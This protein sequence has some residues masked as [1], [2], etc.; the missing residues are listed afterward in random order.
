MISSVLGAPP[1][2]GEKIEPWRLYR[3][4]GK[5]QVTF[6]EC[7]VRKIHRRGRV[8]EKW[9]RKWVVERAMREEG[10]VIANVRRGAAGGERRKHCDH[11]VS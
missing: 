9:M 5:F 10:D 11:A 3:C 8:D 1:C 2:P 6:V 4:W 7:Q